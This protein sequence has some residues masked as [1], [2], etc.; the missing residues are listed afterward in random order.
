MVR[1]RGDWLGR[2]GPLW[3]SWVRQ[4][5]EWQSGQGVVRLAE[6]GSGSVRLAIVWQGSQ[7]K[8]RPG[9]QGSGRVWQAWLGLL[10]SGLVPLAWVW[11]GIVRHAW[12]AT[13]RLGSPWLGEAWCGWHGMVRSVRLGCVIVGLG[14]AG[15]VRSGKQRLGAARHGSVRRAWCVLATHG[16]SG[17][18]LARQA[19]SVWQRQ[20]KV[21]LGRQ[22]PPWSGPLRQDKV[23]QAR[24]VRARVGEVRNG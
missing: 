18:G 4:G 11:S 17:L 12:L 8:V 15:S 3:C 14:L 1:F 22:G 9:E 21:W 10:R 23:R 16:K 7:G 2:R 6:L 13:V 24:L 19:G 20:G 5:R